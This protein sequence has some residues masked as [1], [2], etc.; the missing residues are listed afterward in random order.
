MCSENSTTNRPLQLPTLGV[1]QFGDNRT[2]LFQVR[3]GGSVIEGLELASE[4]ADG[5]A[6]LC[7]RLYAEINNGEDAG[8]AEIKALG[9]LSDTVG[10]LTR[11][12]RRSLEQA[13]EGVSHE[14]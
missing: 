5:V 10:A 12:A 3:D 2:L 14:D 13:A 8:T 11:S 9:F 7:S 6:Q 1:I 4:L